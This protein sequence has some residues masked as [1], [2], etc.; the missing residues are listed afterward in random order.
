M[1]QEHQIKELI[2]LGIQEPNGDVDWATKVV[3]GRQVVERNGGTVVL[4]NTDGSEATARWSGDDQTTR[5]AL[6]ALRQSHV[7]ALVEAK[8]E[9]E[10]KLLPGIV[11]R[12]RLV[13]D[14]KPVPVEVRDLP[15]PRLPGDAEPSTDDLDMLLG[16]VF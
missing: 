8:A 5:G 14:S 15:A 10:Y 12:T 13:I 1:T 2:Q 16:P 9:T 6:I 3:D 11:R 7:N 4:G